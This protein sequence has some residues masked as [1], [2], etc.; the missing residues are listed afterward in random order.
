MLLLF[1][2]KLLLRLFPLSG[3]G[4]LVVL[5]LL[6]AFNLRP[7]IRSQALES[8]SRSSPQVF[9]FPA[10]LWKTSSFVP[11]PLFSFRY[12]YYNMY[13]ASL[14]AAALVGAAQGE[15]LY[16]MYDPM[17]LTVSP[18]MDVQVVHVGKN[19]ANNVTD[20]KFW[21]E[22]LTAAPGSMVQF[23]FWAG[24][25]TVTQSSFD[26][27]CTPLE[28]GAGGTGNGTNAAGIKSGYQPVDVSMPNGEIPT[29]T[30]WIND[31]KPLWFYCAQATHC[32]GGMALAINAE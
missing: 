1:P 19:P 4:F 6:L 30:V 20:S 18:A 8:A 21:P 17:T 9:E 27:P 15:S 14:A 22:N 11:L 5:F 16:A 31:T 23:Q 10:G 12:P 28:P 29:Y 32:Q 2:L 25:H 7:S 24:N 13:F 3:S 26:N